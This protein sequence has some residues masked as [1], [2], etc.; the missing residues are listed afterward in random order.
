MS[1]L[2]KLPIGIQTF[3]KIIENDFV[4]I[5]KTKYLYDL[6]KSASIYFISRPRRF[7]KSLLVSTLAELFDG[8]KELFK[9]TWI[10]K[11][12]YNFE[13]YPVIT[14]DMSS[15]SLLSHESFKKDLNL[16]I[17]NIAAEFKIDVNPED[18]EKFK[19]SKILQ[20][21]RKKTGKQVVVLIDEYDKPLV[22]F[23]HQPDDLKN[24]HALLR[25]FYSTLKSCEKDLRFLLLTGVSKFSKT[26]IFS[27]LNN[28]ND[29]TLTSRYA[30]MLGYTQD[31]MK[32]YFNDH[33]KEF[34]KQKKITEKTV[35]SDLKKW[36]NGYCF[37]TDSQKVYNPY[38]VLVTFD[39]YIFENHWYETGTPTFLLNLIKQ[40]KYDISKID[41]KKLSSKSLGTFEPD[42]IPLEALFFQT[43]YLTIKNYLPEVDL[44]EVGY[45]NYEVA[46][47]FQESLLELIT[48]ISESQSRYII[49]DLKTALL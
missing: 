11:T 25:D 30:A 28:L 9:D 10:Y 39:H 3:R 5:D 20:D 22:D 15:L 48:H 43:G 26:S 18:T 41:G 33:V 49:L 37:N 44:F 13:K 1:N 24:N 35:W 27:G 40:N 42:N 36:Y 4:Y 21:L 16:K 46:K 34:S 6:I 19:F 47:S 8:N 23:L 38:S 17:Q 2:K 14:L 32:N 31:E 29:I 7:G 12:D 45:P